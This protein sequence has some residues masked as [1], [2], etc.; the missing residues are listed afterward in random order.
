MMVEIGPTAMD[1]LLRD[2]Q[3]VVNAKDHYQKIYEDYQKL[4]NQHV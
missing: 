1:E 4:I 2:K 3:K